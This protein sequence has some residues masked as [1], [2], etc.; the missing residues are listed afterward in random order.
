M[1]NTQKSPEGLVT[2]MYLNFL[3]GSITNGFSSGVLKWHA[4]TEV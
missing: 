1:I 3:H 2:V 4:V